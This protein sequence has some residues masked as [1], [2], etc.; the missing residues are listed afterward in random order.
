VERFIYRPPAGLP[1]L[2]FEDECYLAVNKPSGLLSNPGLHADTADCALSRLQD[3]YGA[4]IG[5]GALQLVH[6][7]DCDTS[8]ILVLAKT[9]AAESHLKKQLQARQVSKRYCARVAGLMAEDT[10]LIDAALAPDPDRR[11][12]QRL[13]PL[14]KM[15]LTYFRVLAR[16]GDA[17]G[18]QST[19]A[20]EPETGRTHQLRLHLAS[21]G[22][23]IL[24]D[25]FYGDAAVVA[26]SPRLCLHSWHFSFQHPGGF[27]CAIDAPA[28]AF[29][30]A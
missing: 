25:T 13:D 10:G 3:A 26:A 22:H 16:F 28:P 1:P 14:G 23:P 6:R 30:S 21:L 4:A 17:Q 8:G 18:G 27:R 2:L 15:A 9:K 19:V 12:L 20:L 29:L 7:L 24:G 11:P 5:V